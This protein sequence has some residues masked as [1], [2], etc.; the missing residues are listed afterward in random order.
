MRVLL[1][2][3]FWISYLLAHSETGTVHQVVKFCMGRSVHLLAPEEL[4]EELKATL[5]K[6]EVLAQRIA[7]TDI[8]QL[9]AV[10]RQAAEIPSSLGQRA[11]PIQS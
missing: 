6:R 3:N 4:I 1:D 11:R 10:L 9:L 5:A 2:T 8:E 7:E